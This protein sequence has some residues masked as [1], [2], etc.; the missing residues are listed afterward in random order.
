[1]KTKRLAGALLATAILA[2]ALTA[3]AVNQAGPAQAAAPALRLKA[4]SAHPLLILPLYIASGAVDATQWQDSLMG[5][6]NG[7]PSDIKPHVVIAIENA[8]QVGKVPGSQAERDAF[9]Y[10]LGIAQ[11]NNVP[12]LINPGLGGGNITNVQSTTWMAQQFQTYSVLKGI[13][14]AE[15]YYVDH[16]AIANLFAQIL[17]VAGQNGGL[18]IDNDQNQ[19]GYVE[20]LVSNAN[21]KTAD[22]TYSQNYYPITKN[23]ATSDFK[24]TES[25]LSGLWLS[26]MSGGWGVMND[27]WDWFNRGFTKY[28]SPAISGLNTGSFGAEEDR[29]VTEPETLPAMAMMNG[30]ANGG[31]IYLNEHPAYFESRN[32]FTPAFYQGLLPTFRYAIANPGPTKAQVIARTKAAYWATNGNRIWGGFFVGLSGSDGVEEYNDGRYYIIPSF[33]ENLSQTTLATMFPGVKLVSDGG[34]NGYAKITDGGYLADDNAK[35]AYFQSLYPQMYSGDAFV[36]YQDNGAANNWFLYNSYMNTNT[37]QSAAIRMLSN[38]ASEMDYTL[39]ADTLAMVKEEAGKITVNLNDY[40]AEKDDIWAGW[41]VNTTVRWNTDVNTLF[42]DWIAN[43]YIPSPHDT[44]R[45]NAVITLK[46]LT[47]APTVSISG[48][49]P[50]TGFGTIATTFSNGTFTATIPA[51]GSAQIVFDTSNSLAW[52]EV[53]QN[54][55]TF[56]GSWTSWNDSRDYAGSAKGATAT[57][58]SASYTFTGTGIQWI[59]QKDANFGK[60]SVYIDNVLQSTVD[61][62]NSSNL[63]QQTLFSKTGLS[64][65]AHT[66]KIVP[67]GTHSSSSTDNWIEVDAFAYG[68]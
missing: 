34:A 47:V 53:D 27:T 17:T 63:W 40:R 26:G 13:L 55:A 58:S 64:S 1:M 4:D 11:A 24:N 46:G 12:V 62:Y 9:T 49:S 42:Q 57:G 5:I 68:G 52:H 29:A 22:A 48:Q 50:S 16:T 23:T 20:D 2:G 61:T 32:Q 44:T 35:V 31:S 67:T 38:N 41:D 19:N 30:I 18:F 54:S 8:G 15:N 6:W 21:F 43:S 25:V 36:Q 60:A 3:Q 14:A 59:G 66:I 45:R 7:V 51:N 39:T 65:G 37:S 28:F 33:S 10:W 56:A